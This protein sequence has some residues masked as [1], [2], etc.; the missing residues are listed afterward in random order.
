MAALLLGGAL[1]WAACVA[2]ALGIAS[3]LPYASS[4]RQLE[5]LPPLLAV[6]LTAAFCTALQLLPLPLGL[7]ELLSP[8]RAEVVL[9]ASRALGSSPPTWAALSMDPRATLLELAKFIGYAAFAYAA[10]FV[11]SSG[12]R[13]KKR[14]L[15]AVAGV[16]TAM[17]AVA[18][19]HRAVGAERLFGFYT[20]EST[21]FGFLAPL[22]NPNHLASLCAMSACVSLVLAIATSRIERRCLWIAAMATCTAVTFL[23][24]SRGAAVALF[25]GIAVVVVLLYRLRRARARATPRRGDAAAAPAGWLRW[26]G[27]AIVLACA[28]ALLIVSTASGLWAELANLEAGDLTG[29]EEGKVAAW[30]HAFALISEFFWTGVGRGAF[31]V[32]FPRYHTPSGVAVYSHLENEYLQAFADWG[33]PAGILLAGLAARWALRAFPQALSGTLEA[34]AAAAL[35]VVALHSLIDFGLELPAI[36]LPAIALAALLSPAA[37]RATKSGRPRTS[38]RI[39]VAV[40]ALFVIALSAGPWSRSARASREA[41]LA[42]PEGQRKALAAET[43]RRHPA[44]YVAAAVMAQALFRERDNRALKLASWSLFLNPSSTSV[45]LLTG[46]MLIAAGLPGQACGEFHLALARA[47]RPI[48]LVNGIVKLL[49]PEAISAHCF[50]LEP[51]LS[52]QVIDRLKRLQKPKLALQVARDAAALSPDDAEVLERLGSLELSHGDPASAE[53]ALREISAHQPRASATVML[54][55]VFIAT[56]RHDEA[57]ELLLS[58]ANQAAVARDRIV[59]FKA[60]ADL[61]AEQGA[62]ER[63]KAILSRALRDAGEDRPTRASIHLRLSR[64]ESALGNA[65]RAEWE[66]R[67]A[68]ELSRQP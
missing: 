14:L 35:V 50:P 55:D 32:S 8:W 66:A 39:A 68:E 62:H 23:Q 41:L 22:L 31:E 21:S 53:R 36:A 49:P 18:I 5:R 58:S 33:V 20:P 52:I 61:Y 60:L 24:R 48:P 43:M 56:N 26:L 25:A 27:P 7:V 44:D 9:G 63:A 13:A 37:P 30:R 2:G 64:V 42:A 47:P 40:A 54:A 57:T 46:R 15:A 12:R 6:L 38:L 19:A 29:R 10:I 34:G 51:H 65:H 45:H 59:L 1:Q 67:R 4:R 3:T 17:A 28:L 16:G 11:A